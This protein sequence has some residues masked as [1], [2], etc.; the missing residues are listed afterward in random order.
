MLLVFHLQSSKV[1]IDIGT[2]YTDTRFHVLPHRPSLR[3][4]SEGDETFR[5][6]KQKKCNDVALPPPLLQTQ[7]SGGR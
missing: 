7:M 6:P 2:W 1:D 5:A 4:I 3:P